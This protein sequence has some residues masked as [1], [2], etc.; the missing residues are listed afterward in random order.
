VNETLSAAANR[1]GITLSAEQLSKID[2]LLAVLAAYNEHT[3][4]VAKADPEIV[5]RDHVLDSLTVVPHVVAHSTKHAVPR[6]LIDIG[7]GAGFPGLILAIA[8][9]D[10]EVHLVDSVGKKTRF[11]TE[12]A[13]ALGLGDRVT[14][15]TARAEEM[16]HDKKL[17]ETFSLATA[18][19][20]GKLALVAELALPLLAVNGQLLAQKSR[21]QAAA[22]AA[23][24]E[25]AIAT[26]GGK[27]IGTEPCPPEMTSR[28]VVI[29]VVEKATPTP[30]RLPRPSA[31]LKRPL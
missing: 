24:A 10:L 2:K 11:L 3:N 19:A 31:Q 30:T 29:V 25:S 13:D 23:E 1:L 21:D 22:E 28:D 8:C 7:S 6:R 9:P 5:V 18:R 20:V 15:H 17:R 14:V 4:L 27:I 16:A 12:A 26:L